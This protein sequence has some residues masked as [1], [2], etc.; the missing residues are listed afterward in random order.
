MCPVLLIHSVTQSP[1]F[2]LF[3]RENQSLYQ[4][5]VDLRQKHEEQEQVVNK[6]GVFLNVI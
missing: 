6:V 3:N 4:E 1:K 5:L 2:D